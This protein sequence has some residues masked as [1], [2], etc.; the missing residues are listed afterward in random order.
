VNNLRPIGPAIRHH[1]GRA[2]VVL[3]DGSV[4]FIKDSISEPTLW[5]LGSGAQGEVLSSDSY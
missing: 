2:N 5:A 1:P 3:L 4:K